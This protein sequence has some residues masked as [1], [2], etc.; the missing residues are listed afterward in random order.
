MSFQE[1]WKMRAIAICQMGSSKEAQKALAQRHPT[2]PPP[3][4]TTTKNK[5]A[6][7]L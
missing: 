2:P 5:I 1:V 7:S 3:S 6:F 4:L